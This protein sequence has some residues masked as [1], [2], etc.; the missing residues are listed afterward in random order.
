MLAGFRWVNLG[1]KLDGALEP[2]TISWEAPFWNTTTIN[3]LYGLQ[4]GADGNFRSA[5]AFPSTPLVKAGLFDNDAE[6]TTEVS[7][8]A[9]Q[10][11]DQRPLRPI[12]PPSSAKPAC[13]AS[14][15]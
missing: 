10:L 1:E 4:V 8:I 11:R 14:I 12:T 15:K 2:P 7:V 5:A 9:K 6:E 3:N 13:C